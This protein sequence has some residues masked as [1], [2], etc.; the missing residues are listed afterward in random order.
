MIS[1]SLEI[2]KAGKLSANRTEIPF[3]IPLRAK[4]SIK[5]LYET[6]HGVFINIQVVVIRS[7]KLYYLYLKLDKTKVCS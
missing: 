7:S 2:S 1:F 4:S 6:Y 5:H 3:E